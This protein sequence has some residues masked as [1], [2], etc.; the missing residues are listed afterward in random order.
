MLML[1]R[2]DSA[3]PLAVE[4]FARG[5]GLTCAE[6]RV[7]LA[8]CN[9]KTPQQIAREASVE[10]STVRSQIVSVRQKTGARDLRTLVA[11]VAALPPFVGVLAQTLGIHLD[12]DRPRLG[13][14]QALVST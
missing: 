1:S 8:L 13:A 9:G 14:R 5:K 3:A 7:L 2:R 10:M 6:T 11:Q 4:A 12:G